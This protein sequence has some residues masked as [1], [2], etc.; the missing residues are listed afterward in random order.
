MIQWEETGSGVAA[1]DAADNHVEV[2]APD[3]RPAARQRGVPRPTDAELTGV[4]VRLSVPADGVTVTTPGARST[5][6]LAAGE[7]RRLDAGEYVVEADAA[8]DVTVAFAGPAVLERDDRLHV[9]FRDATSVGVGFTSGT[10]APADTI[11]IP[12]TLDGVATAITHAA[13]AHRTTSPDRSAAAY[14]C[15]PPAFS[16]GDAVDV[17]ESVAAATPDTGIELV[18]PR[19]LRALF[20]AAPLAYYLGADVTVDGDVTPRLR[21]PESG[22]H[23]T[24]DALAVDGPATLARAF[25]L[26]CLVRAGA[27]PGVS[28]AP[29]PD[30]AALDGRDA[31]DELGIDPAAV[32]DATPADRLATYLDAPFERVADDLPEWHLSM[33]VASNLDHVRTLPFLLDRLAFVYPPETATL[34]SQELM[35]RSLDD[36]YRGPPGPV[37]TVEM[38]KPKL[39][40]GRWQGW[41][42]DGTPIDVFKSHPAA[43]R[44]HLDYVR[45]GASDLSVAVVLN[46]RSMSGEHEAVADIYG[47]HEESLPM[48]VSFFENLTRA[49]LRDVFASHYEFVHYIGHCE[50]EGLRCADGNLAVADLDETNVETF[51][52][53][54]CGSYYEGLDLVKRGSVAGAVT[55]R[56]VLDEQAAKV[57]TAFARLLVHGFPIETALRLARRRIR[58]GK[59]YAVVGDGMQTLSQTDRDAVR[60]AH[61]E[62][63]EDACEVSYEHLAADAHGS[64]YDV[65]VDG[66][67]APQLC[68]NPTE[69][70]MPPADLAGVFDEA[71]HPVIVD[72]EFYWADEAATLLRADVS[73]A[74]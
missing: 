71:D 45:D 48:D 20:V 26:D 3:W 15:H 63:G 50:V 60:V 38:L 49:G 69:F 9:V 8:I 53:N 46:D 59:D 22:V 57:G 58:M 30:G 62:R 25:W 64:W 40:D 43:Y 37:A 24:F 28:N 6:S 44:N 41:L 1:T 51:F 14:R 52:L 47:E 21:A 10:H 56:K 19:S 36:F 16:F 34:E 5:V 65:D 55:L 29:A 12:K 39:R 33:H 61:V 70:T 66:A 73:T 74:K 23:E 68:G 72:G 42:A 2:R 54:A 18:L 4:A 35:E 13:A 11:T 17:P 31:L 7:Q 67:G 32:Y 27:P